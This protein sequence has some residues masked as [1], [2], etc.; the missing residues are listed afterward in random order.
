M[1]ASQPK[2]Q[3]IDSE[4]CE[5]NDYISTRIIKIIKNETNNPLLEKY[6]DGL[7]GNDSGK[8]GIPYNAIQILFLQF[9]N[10]LH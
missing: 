4:F 6:I 5:I 8:V 9:P 7:Y 1:D 10:Q 2:K 3:Q